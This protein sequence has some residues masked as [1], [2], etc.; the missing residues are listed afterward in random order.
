[1][2]AET[3]MMS[4]F[5]VQIQTDQKCLSFSSDFAIVGAMGVFVRNL[6]LGM[7]T[8]VAVRV[9]R[10]PDEVTLFGVVCAHYADL[11]LVIQFKPTTAR[12]EQRLATVL[13]A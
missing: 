4:P 6:Q 13:A 2:T 7:G 1:M 9:C 8:P 12:M 3:K 11:G 10:G 5:V